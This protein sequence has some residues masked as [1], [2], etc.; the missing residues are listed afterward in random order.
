[1]HVITTV[2]LRLNANFVVKCT[3]GKWNLQHAT[4]KQIL[5][6]LTNYTLVPS[7]KRFPPWTTIGVEAGTTYVGPETIETS[8]LNLQKP[9]IIPEHFSETTT[10]L[11]IYKSQRPPDPSQ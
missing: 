8:P 11:N 7:R 6:I 2:S 4:L 3:A 1:M 9:N 10:E 5:Q